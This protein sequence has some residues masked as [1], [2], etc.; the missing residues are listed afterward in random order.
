MGLYDTFILK[1]PIQCR[2]CYSGGY[3]DFQTKDLGEHMVTYVEGE[4]AVMYGLREI[5]EDEKRERHEEFALL[6]PNLAET[7][8]ES[9]CG[10]FRMDK[11]VIVDKLPDG[12]YWAY[13]WCPNCKDLFYVSMEVKGG[14]FIGVHND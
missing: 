5:N 7:V 11:S 13:E 14:I 4:P 3:Y 9:T 2:N 10:M 1:V 12:I 6:Y 8:W